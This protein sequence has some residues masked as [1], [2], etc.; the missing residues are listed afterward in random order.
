MG[1]FR[2]SIAGLLVLIL[3]CAIG[4]AA[5]RSASNAWVAVIVT[6]ASGLILLAIFQ[7]AFRRGPIRSFGA[8][9]AFMA[10]IYLGMSLG[11]ELNLPT[12]SFLR[13]RNIRDNQ[14]MNGSVGI[15]RSIIKSWKSSRPRS[16]SR[17]SS[18][19]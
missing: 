9:Y 11:L 17:A 19:R 2:T 3:Y 13:R 14:R 4:L 12:T 7:A 6:I 18:V 15:A 16:G 8:G 1:T 5:L 10:L